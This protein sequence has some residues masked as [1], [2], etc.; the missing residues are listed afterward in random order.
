MTPL[1]Y[2]KTFCMN[3]KSQLIVLYSQNLCWLLFDRKKET[4]L[5]LGNKLGMK[6]VK[7]FF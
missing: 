6:F 1:G 2:V 7:T 4:D 5:E 3:T